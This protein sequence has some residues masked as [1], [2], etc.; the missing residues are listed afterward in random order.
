MNERIR[1]LALQAGY[2]ADMFGIGHW[3]MPECKKFFEL[4]VEECEKVSLKNSHRDDMGAIIAR[5]IKQHF[6][7]E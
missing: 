1:E 7:V 3:D 5:Q 6:G 4:I 2:Q